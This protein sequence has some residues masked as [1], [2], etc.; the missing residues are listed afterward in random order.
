[1]KE[2]RRASD[3]ESSRGNRPKVSES[4]AGGA[5]VLVRAAV[6]TEV[7]SE[8]EVLLPRLITAI[9]GSR[10]GDWD[11]CHRHVKAYKGNDEITD[12]DLTVH[13]I[14]SLYEPCLPVD[15]HGLKTYAVHAV[16]KERRV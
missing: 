12:F 2:S 5:V 16:L 7:P 14:D 8:S 10:H 15:I 3:K 4:L 11:A 6:D 1:M 13:T 9:V